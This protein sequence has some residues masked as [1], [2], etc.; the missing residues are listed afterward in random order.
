MKKRRGTHRELTYQIIGMY[1]RDPDMRSRIQHL[2]KFVLSLSFGSNYRGTD[3][4]LDICWDALDRNGQ[5]ENGIAPW[6]DAMGALGR[7]LFV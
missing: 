3:E 2:L 7:N 5:Y 4:I 6:R 1:T